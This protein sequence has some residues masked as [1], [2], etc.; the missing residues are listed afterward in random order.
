M[1]ALILSC[2]KMKA[3]GATKDDVVAALKESTIE[4][5]EGGAAVRRPANASL[6]KLEERPQHA[7]KNSIHAHDGGVVAVFK[8]VP[9]E[10]SW[11]QIKEKLKEKLPPKVALWFVSEVTDKAECF[12]SSAPFEGGL[13]FF[14]S[15]ELEVGDSKLKCDV[16]YG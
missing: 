2:N 8:N 16:C 4:V 15:L 14:D 1:G 10:K 5:K 7:K 9:E 6:P 3:L 13:Q 12:L 11:T